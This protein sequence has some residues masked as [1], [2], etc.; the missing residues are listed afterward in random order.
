MC[1]S[2]F[3][4]GPRDYSLYR[5]SSAHFISEIGYHGCPAVSSLR[6]FIP[7]KDLWPIQND[8]WDAHNTEYTLCIRDW[9]TT[10]T[11]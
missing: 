6:Q 9:G 5:H 10:A 4:R 1:R 3:F 8:A 2:S 7:E 11:S